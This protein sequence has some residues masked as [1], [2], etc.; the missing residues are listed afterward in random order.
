VKPPLQRLAWVL[1]SQ[2]TPPKTSHISLFPKPAPTKVQ[3]DP[4]ANTFIHRSERLGLG[5]T[6]LTTDSDGH[7]VHTYEYGNDTNRGILTHIKIDPMGHSWPSKSPNS[8]NKTATLVEG[9]EVIMEFFG[10]WTL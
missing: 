8:D 1:F 3:T 4:I 6:N 9:T 10:R 5:H 7:Q 2:N